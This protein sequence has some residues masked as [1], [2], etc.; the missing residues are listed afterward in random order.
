MLAQNRRSHCHRCSTTTLFT[1]SGF[2]PD[3]SL[4]LLCTGCEANGGVL[5]RCPHN[6]AFMSPTWLPLLLAG[7]DIVCPKCKAAYDLGVKIEPTFPEAG[8]ALQV[9]GI[10]VGAVILVGV[11]SEVLKR[12]KGQL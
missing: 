1:T 7:I 9:A 10:V 11:I 3:G 12:V 5:H 8:E 4:R 6:G 2:Y